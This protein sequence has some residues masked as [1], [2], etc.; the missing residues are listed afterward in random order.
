M[1]DYVGMVKFIKIQSLNFLIQMSQRDV[2]SDIRC[3]CEMREIFESCKY[4]CC[5]ILKNLFNIFEFYI[6]FFQNSYYNLFYRVSMKFKY[7]ELCV[8]VFKNVNIL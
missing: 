6:L 8:Y 2:D 1:M 4:F 7:N 5:V 3:R